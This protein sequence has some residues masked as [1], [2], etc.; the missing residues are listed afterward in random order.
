MYI[1]QYGCG[2]TEGGCLGAGGAPRFEE[3]GRGQGMGC[4]GGGGLVADGSKK[5]AMVWGWG[6]TGAGDGQGVEEGCRVGWWGGG[7]GPIR[8]LL[9]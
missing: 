7:G 4:R 3:D 5:V 6:G 1:V 9:T 2:R 8:S